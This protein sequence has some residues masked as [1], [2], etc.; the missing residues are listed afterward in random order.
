MQKDVITAAEAAPL[1]GVTKGRVIQ[2][3]AEGKLPATRFG[4]QYAIRRGD[5]ELVRH[6]KRGRP[7]AVRE[8]PGPAK[9]R[10]QSQHRRGSRGKG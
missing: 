2:L 1:L 5:L 8:K 4:L 3:I 9:A 7:P 6:R 10:K